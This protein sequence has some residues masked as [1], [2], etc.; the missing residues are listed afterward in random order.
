MRCDHDTT[1]ARRSTICWPASS[2]SKSGRRVPARARGRQNA[3]CLHNSPPLSS[4]AAKPLHYGDLWSHDVRACTR[5][6]MGNRQTLST[7]S[8]AANA[9]K[10]VSRIRQ[11]LSAESA[12]S[13]VPVALVALRTTPPGAEPL[14][15]AR[16]H[17]AA[18]G[19]NRS[20]SS[21]WSRNMWLSPT[22]ALEGAG[23]AVPH[24]NF[25]TRRHSLPRWSE[26]NRSSGGAGISSCTL[27]SA[28]DVLGVG[29]STEPIDQLSWRPRLCRR[30]SRS[31]ARARR[32]PTVLVLSAH[33]IRLLGCLRFDGS[34]SSRSPR[35]RVRRQPGPTR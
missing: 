15:Y 31:R 24:N 19:E 25:Q 20:G 27:E 23:R 32:A 16:K 4:V 33:S 35:L 12:L 18:P 7:D 29:R 9:A 8:T 21:P 30:A 26:R 6:R 28:A 2:P 34:V 10:A 13:V 5:G 3:H 14:N 22:T 1:R 17:W 11:T